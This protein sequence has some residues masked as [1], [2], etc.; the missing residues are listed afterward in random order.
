MLT[1]FAENQRLPFDVNYL[2]SLPYKLGAENQFGKGE[3][4]VLR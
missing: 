3:T 2:R 1:I 4:V